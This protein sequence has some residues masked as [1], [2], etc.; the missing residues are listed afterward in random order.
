V[1]LGV[2]DCFAAIRLLM[3]AIHREDIPMSQDLITDF[4]SWLTG[5][6]DD[7]HATLLGYQ[8]TQVAGIRRPPQP[9]PANQRP[10]RLPIANRYSRDPGPRS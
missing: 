6:A 7:T 5:Y 10:R 3:N 2:G 4:T 8:I 1:A 9:S